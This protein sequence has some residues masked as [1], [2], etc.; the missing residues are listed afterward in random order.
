GRVTLRVFSSAQLPSIP[1]PTRL[2]LCL[3]FTV[4]CA[5]PA[6]AQD[7]AA[8]ETTEPQTFV[9]M[10]AAA[11]IP[12]TTGAATVPLGDTAEIMLPDGYSAVAR[13]GLEAFYSLTHNAMNGSE[14]GV[15]IAPAPNEWM[16]FFDYD[17]VGY[18]KDDEQD[19]LD[20]AALMESLTAG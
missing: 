9:E 13:A 17:P 3:A 8:T 1:M 11:G 12:L 4:G 10:L 2:L 14:V 18:I 5:T 16:L 7:A 20:A 6:F 19:D 15:I